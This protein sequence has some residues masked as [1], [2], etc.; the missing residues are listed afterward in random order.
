MVESWVGCDVMHDDDCACVHSY[1]YMGSR[2]TYTYIGYTTTTK[3]FSAY[4]LRGRSPSSV[5]AK[6][7]S[8]SGI[9]GLYHRKGFSF[10][11][12]KVYG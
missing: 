7:L 1:V 5:S 10:K 12:Q 8:R 6:P 3:R 2:P 11:P 9:T 4:T